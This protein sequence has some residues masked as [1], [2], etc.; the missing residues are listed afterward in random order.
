MHILN[1]IYCKCAAFEIAIRGQK[2]K[3]RQN[4]NLSYTNITLEK[5]IEEVCAYNNISD[6]E[7]ELLHRGRKFVN[8]VKL[9]KCDKPD[10]PSWKD[11]IEAFETAWEICNKYQLKMCY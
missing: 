10:F 1:I 9:H 11:G 8:M 3:E 7:K 4:R 2:N 6:N 5:T